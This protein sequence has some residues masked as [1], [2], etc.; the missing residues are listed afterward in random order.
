M[1]HA[2]EINVS[3]QFTVIKAVHPY[4]NH[5]RSRLHIGSI[6]KVS[7]ADRHNEDIGLLRQLLHVRRAGMAHRNRCILA[8]QQQGHRLADDIAATD[9]D[10]M[11]SGHF[12]SG[13]LDE[14]DYACRR[15]R[16]QTIIADDQVANVDRVEAVH[17]FLHCDRID[18]CFLLDM[19]RQRKLN[20][21][22]VN[23][24]LAI[25]LVHERKQL[26]LRGGSR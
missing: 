26:F 18:D 12:N 5:D 3:R 6:H 9:D 4:V 2:L 20:E 8:L 13:T 11:L 22:A 15:A 21:N 14:F 24:A 17:V 16:K 19:T 10:G 1:L 7:P 25:Q 23:I